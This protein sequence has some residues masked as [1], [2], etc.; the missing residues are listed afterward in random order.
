M[1]KQTGVD[2]KILR[3]AET[4]VDVRH[5]AGGVITVKAKTP[6]VEPKERLHD[7]FAR[8]ARERPDQLFI[9]ERKTPD[10]PF[11][12]LTYGQAYARARAIA[13]GLAE[14]A[15]GVDRPIA[16]LSGNSVNH[17]ILGLAA[18][19]A[20]VPYAPISP[21]YSTLSAD[22]DRL[23]NIF[24]VLDPGLVYAEDGATFARALALPEMAGREI[25]VGA[26]ADKIAGA[27]VFDDLLS[28]HSSDKLDAVDAT[29]TLDT[30]AK[31]LFTSGSTGTPKGVITTHRMLTSSIEQIRLVWPFLEG[32]NPVILDWLPWSHVFG[33]SFSVAFALRYR[34]TFYIDDGRPLPKEF[35]KT[36]RNLRE[37][38]PTFYWS[39]PK[40]YEFLA[41]DLERDEALRES[42]F[43]NLR[44]MFYAGA[45]LPAPIFEALERFARRTG[46]DIP[47]LTSWGL[48]ETAPSITIV[49]RAG[50]GVGNVGTPMPGLEL[51]LLPNHGKLE[52]R[53]R[54]PNVTP[55]YWKMPEATKEAFDLDGY[56]KTGDALLFAF[57]TDPARGMRFDGRI[58]EDFKLLTGVWANVGDI[59]MR[60]LE[61]LHG[62]A[63]NVVVTAPDRDDLGLLI[64]AAPDCNLDDPDYLKKIAEALARHN[65]KHMG[66]SQ[67][68]ARA[69]VM[70]AP[71]SLDSG[72]M[73]DKG[74]LNS[75]LILQKRAYDVERLYRGVDEDVIFPAE[76]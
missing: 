36:S 15:L 70:R 71:P 59:R 25:V 14:R 44:F 7:L 73:T 9:A 64:I 47:M 23:K 62:L 19:M 31:F 32:L 1:T 28:A 74:S 22:F 60:A 40:G 75:R 65:A 38:S 49:N 20:G 41:A 6:F 37:I 21:P 2:D 57:E 27:L 29:I 68:L 61:A 58:S 39:V 5:G 54:G 35:W 69:M 72:E 51:K 3:F 11:T 13:V 17:Q 42:F 34:G 55:G 52:A 76:N 66:A 53:V 10:A 56:F 26:D 45:S 18:M 63:S 46:R 67:R 33:G 30:I 24:A 16:I 50:A 48:T 43:A 12:G 4:A 8:R